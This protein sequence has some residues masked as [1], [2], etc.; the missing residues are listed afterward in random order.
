[1][2]MLTRKMWNVV[3]TGFK[4]EIVLIKWWSNHQKRK[5]AN[6]IRQIL[7][8]LKSLNLDS[9]GISSPIFINDFYCVPTIK[10]S[11][12][13]VK[14]CD[15]INIYIYS[16]FRTVFFKKTSCRKVHVQLQSHMMLKWRTSLQETQCWK[17]IRRTE[18]TLTNYRS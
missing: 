17:I 13:N 18:V 9:A 6:K 3:T 4:L 10:S 5:Y 11:G 2:L 1:M 16:G 7:K 12:P 14:S 8:K 15:L